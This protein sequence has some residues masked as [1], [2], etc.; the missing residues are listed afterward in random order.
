MFPQSYV[1]TV[2]NVGLILVIFRD[3]NDVQ[4]R[5]LPLKALLFKVYVRLNHLQQ[6]YILEYF[7]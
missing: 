5:K 4:A 6:R 7:F 3:R 2:R 1:I